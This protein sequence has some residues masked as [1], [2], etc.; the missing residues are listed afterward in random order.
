MLPRFVGRRGSLS[1]LSPCLPSILAFGAV[2]GPWCRLGTVQDFGNLL[3]SHDCADGKC[4][5]QWSHCQAVL[6]SPEDVATPAAEIAMLIRV[7]DQLTERGLTMLEGEPTPRFDDSDGE[8]KPWT[9]T[10]HSS[11]PKTHS[12]KTGAGRSRR[13]GFIQRLQDR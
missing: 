2:V 9:V 10:Y 3:D 1:V 8:P 12:A 11:V 6:V 7:R 5:G 13:R 4:A